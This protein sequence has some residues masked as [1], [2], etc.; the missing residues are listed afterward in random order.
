MQ[1]VT[2]HVMEDQRVTGGG[3]TGGTSLLSLSSTTGCDGFHASF[4]YELVSLRVGLT[5]WNE[6]ELSTKLA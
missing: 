1:K 5:R 3:A 2:F 4:F 6:V